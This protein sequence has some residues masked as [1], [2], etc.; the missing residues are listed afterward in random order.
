MLS[1]SPLDRDQHMH[2]PRGLRQEHRRLAGRVAA[3]DHD[4][5]FAAGTAAIRRRSRRSRCRRPRTAASLLDRELPVFGAG[6][7]DHRARRHA[8]RLPRSRS[9]T[10]CGCTRAASRPC[11][12][13]T[14]RAELL[15][16]HVGAPG[17][18]LP[19]DAGRESQD[20]SRSA[21]WSPPARPGEVDLD[22]Q[23][24]ETF[25]GAVDGRGQ[26]GRS[27]ADDHQVADLRPGR[28]PR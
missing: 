27:G 12:I 3:A 15:R 17:E 18:L 26:P 22:D 1:A 9:H 28:S 16:L 2:A 24:V 13:I 5:V 10:A 7:D 25:R 20:S 19:G 23:D 6:R 8:A 14:S 11:A 21:S 4:D